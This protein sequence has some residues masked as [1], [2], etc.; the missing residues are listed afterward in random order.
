[1]SDKLRRAL[2]AV[3]AI[4]FCVSAAAFGKALMEYHKG[5][6]IYESAMEYVEETDITAASETKEEKT[7]EK[8][9]QDTPVSN[10]K[11][12][13]ANIDFAGMQA[14]NADVIG[15]IQIM[16]T[17]VDYPLLDADDNKYYL[18]HTYDHRRSSYGSI[19]IEPRNKPD[20]SEDHLVIYGHNMVNKS[21]F[22]SLL[23]FKQQS[24]ANNH[25]IITICMPGKD[26]TYRVFSAYTAHVD[27][28]TYRMSF[29]GDASF[30][31]MISYMKENSV[32]YSDITP[33]V[34]DQILTLSTCTPA[35]ARDYRFVV[36]AVLIDGNNLVSSVQENAVET[37]AK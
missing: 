37:E 5:N 4:V 11:R 13:Y 28:A 6:E 21:M 2:M 3:L 7:E 18:N 23:N 16:G 26:L 36:N 29:S 19:F 33:K 12:S 20:L 14:I 15:W 1:M 9:Q 17:Q 25:N 32:I 31:E 27:S 35:G 30:Q 10:I 8:E 22:G 34:G 24:Y